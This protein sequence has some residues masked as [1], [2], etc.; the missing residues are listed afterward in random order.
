MPFRWSLLVLFL[1]FLIPLLTLSRI[2]GSSIRSISKSKG[3]STKS[4]LLLHHLQEEEHL[5][6][7]SAQIRLDLEENDLQ[8][9]IDCTIPSSA[10][11]SFSTVLSREERSLQEADFELE[12][13]LE[14]QRLIQRHQYDSTILNESPSALQRHL[15]RRLRSQKRHMSAYLASLRQQATLSYVSQECIVWRAKQQQLLLE[16]KQG[17]ERLF[18][19]SRENNSDNSLK[20]FTRA[21]ALE[22]FKQ[23]HSYRRNLDPN[24]IFAQTLNALALKQYTDTNGF[25]IE[26]D[27]TKIMAGSRRAS[28]YQNDDIHVL[29]LDMQWDP[30]VTVVVGNVLDETVKLRQEGYRPVM[31][32]V[33][34]SLVPGGDYHM[35]N[36][37]DNEAD[38][39]RRTTIYQ[40]LDQEP[41]RSR[42]YPLQENGGVYC[43]NQ[44]V[45]RH[46][47][48]KNNDFMDRFEWISV[49]SVPP[50]PELETREK[51]GGLGGVQFLEG[52]DDILR[53]K[54]LAAMKV[55]VS[56]GHDALVL[57]PH[58][59]DVGQNP[60]EAIAAIYRS[61]IGRD[62]MGGRK[63]FQTYKKIVMVLDPEQAYKIVN[64]TSSYRPT[65]P[66]NSTATGTPLPIQDEGP[67]K[68][69]ESSDSQTGFLPLEK[70]S[71]QEYD[72]I[73]SDKVLDHSQ[74]HENDDETTF[75]QSSVDNE[76]EDSGE[77]KY[78]SENLDQ[79][80][81]WD[82]SQTDTG[83][84]DDVKE[85]GDSEDDE[86]IE[87][88]I[89]GNE[90]PSADQL[91][92]EDEVSESEALL[93]EQDLEEN[94]NLSDKA[95]DE[96]LSDV[97]Q[98]S[99]ADPLPS[100]DNSISEDEQQILKEANST[101]VNLFE[102]K[103]ATEDV[104]EEQPAT[105][106]F[107][108]ITETVQE[109]FERMLEPRSLL[110][111]KNRARGLLDSDDQDSG[112][113]PNNVTV[114][115]NSTVFATP[116][117]NSTISVPIS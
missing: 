8:L 25:V 101:A 103:E 63:R 76:L 78:A 20:S 11:E 61:I 70:R 100:E 28:A 92:L 56:Q 98:I 44:A 53:R 77:D 55:G 117:S 6:S 40:C 60:A 1:L 15:E 64:E 33:G 112:K 9:E 48:D 89:G 97:P 24:S 34:N 35:D 51:E 81:E 93:E 58:G 19:T 67:G 13:S 57:P 43:P 107:V 69:D 108:Q 5:R 14:I 32:N 91:A 82:D 12:L 4:S 83:S 88:E 113:S 115:A 68:L 73:D 38:L 7:R 3:S 17:H 23:F 99:E 104:L 22:R 90:E 106:E 110:I 71:D 21:N 62:F 37:T 10:T 111:V 66:V 49:V 26:L 27:S 41:R 52:E 74:K 85:I 75:I 65:Q 84:L 59:T 31:L 102:E 86:N 79:N 80:L 87:D 47:L 16:G 116:Q 114:N 36:V 109:V 45:F 46:G 94:A 29:V 96:D 105:E 95:L 2:T 39:F 54:I 72:S 30:E 50:I 42:F 18:S